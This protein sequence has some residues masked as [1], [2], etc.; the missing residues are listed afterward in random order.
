MFKLLLII[1]RIYSLYG[2]Y[3]YYGMVIDSIFKKTISKSI[4]LKH[5]IY[6]QSDKYQFRGRPKRMSEVLKTVDKKNIIKSKKY[7]VI[8]IDEQ[9]ELEYINL[10]HTSTFFLVNDN[11]F[12]NKEYNLYN[13]NFCFL[14]NNDFNIDKLSYYYITISPEIDNT[15]YEYILQSIIILFIVLSLFMVFFIIKTCTTKNNLFI[16]VYNFANSS[17]GF[18]FSIIFSCM[19][20]N[21]VLLSYIFYSLF[22]SYI[23]LHLI[24]LLNGYSIIHYNY[25]FKQKFK[26]GLYLFLYESLTTIIFIYIVYFIPSFNNFYLF[27]IRN[28]FENIILLIINII[29]IKKIFFRL[30][31]KY[32]LER[33]LR[34]VLTLVYKIKLIIYSKVIIFSFL[35]S[36]I[37]MSMQYIQLRYKI[38]FYSKGFIMN[39]YINI[40]LEII[41]AIILGITFFPIKISVLYYYPINIDYDSLIFVSEIKE[42]NNNISK[43]TKKKLINEYQKKEYPLVLILPFCKNTNEFNQFYIG[44]T[45]I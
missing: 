20:I 43:L 41:F 7:K 11:K 9:S 24:L 35:Y 12:Q 14:E 15:F 38:H 23:L 30:Y 28:I 45:K 4:N 37:F 10:F 22:K 27:F 21:Y 19:T 42:N 8:F 2:Q 31:Q 5:C 25:S 16:Y 26:Y 40:C 3:K 36:I 17:I 6:L 33:R 29:M 32:R 13:E 1:I 18:C 39:Y 34:T 44:Q